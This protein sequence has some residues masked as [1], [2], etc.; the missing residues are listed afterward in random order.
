[1]QQRKGL[2]TKQTGEERREILETTK[3]LEETLYRHVE[4]DEQVERNNNSFGSK[5]MKKKE[6]SVADFLGMLTSH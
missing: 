4:R 5:T 3:R 2:V 6:K 1:L